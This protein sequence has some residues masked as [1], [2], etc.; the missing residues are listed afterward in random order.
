[1]SIEVRSA[2]MVSETKR[3][4]VWA[5]LED[6]LRN[7]AQTL[8]GDL[9]GARKALSTLLVDRVKF[10][11]T[12]PRGGRRTYELQAELTLGLMLSLAAQTCNVPDGI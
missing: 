1:V 7:L 3:R 9:V 12:E 5:V 2:G 4:R 8:R 6:L 10:T 11:P